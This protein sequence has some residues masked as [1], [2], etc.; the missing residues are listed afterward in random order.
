MEDLG[1]QVQSILN[2]PDQMAKVM[3]LAGQLGL[4]PE[5]PAAPPE[6]GAR[7]AGPDLTALGAM[8]RSAGGGGRTGSVLRSLSPLLP[9]EKQ[10]QLER[11]IR[12]AALS[13]LLRS[14]LSAHGSEAAHV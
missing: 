4:S 7:T 6:P 12:A 14:A 8:L 2:N 11:A 13:G 3:E 9:E 1:A 10:P 5:Q